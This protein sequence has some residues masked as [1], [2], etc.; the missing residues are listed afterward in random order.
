MELQFEKDLPHQKAAVE[1][2]LQVTETLNVE[3]SLNYCANKI[4]QPVDGKIQSVIN[5]LQKNFPTGQ[6][7]VV[8]ANEKFGIAENPCL[9]IDVKMETGTGKTYVYTETIYELHKQLGISKFILVVPGKAIKAGAANFM[10]D[11]DVKRHFRST[12][13]YGSEIRLFEGTE[14]KSKNKKKNFPSA[15]SSFYQNPVYRINISQCFC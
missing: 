5:R 2:I 11:P 15:V 4:L 13:G 3:Q 6:K 1:S 9:Y 12:C 14:Q 10:N 8:S 7:C